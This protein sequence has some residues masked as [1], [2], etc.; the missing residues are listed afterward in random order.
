MAVIQLVNKKIQ[1]ALS[2]NE[3]KK[4]ILNSCYK[5]V[6]Y[7]TFDKKDPT[8]FDDDDFVQAMNLGPIDFKL[9]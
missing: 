4:M 7:K 8:Q 2:S 1:P 3:F 6:V 9:E 5:E